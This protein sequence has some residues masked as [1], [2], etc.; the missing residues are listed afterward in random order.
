MTT[1][2]SDERIAEIRAREQAAT[3]G[4]WEVEGKSHMAFACIVSSSQYDPINDRQR[5]IVKMCGIAS[6][7]GEG[8]NNASFIANA[9]QDVPDLLTEVTR[10]RSRVARLEGVLRSVEWEGDPHDQGT[11]CPVCRQWWHGTGHDHAPDCEL[12]A[13]LRDADE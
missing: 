6:P 12:D 2:L 10:L 13:A 11:I 8:S 7:A 9:R 3:P 5:R 1:L 4:P